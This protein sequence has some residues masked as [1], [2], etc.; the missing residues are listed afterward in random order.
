MKINM[1]FLLAVHQVIL[2]IKSKLEPRRKISVASPLRRKETELAR[3]VIAIVIV[4]VEKRK[5]RKRKKKKEK[6]MIPRKARK[7]VTSVRNKLLNTS[8]DKILHVRSA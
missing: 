1:I 5:L 7:Y 4:N 3:D 2:L 6:L 8:I